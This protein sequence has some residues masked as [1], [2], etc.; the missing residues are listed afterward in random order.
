MGGGSQIKDRI[1]CALPFPE[2]VDII[3]QLR[4]R[5]SSAEITYI[6]VQ[7]D[8]DRKPI[9]HVPIG[10]LKLLLSD[11]S[12][13]GIIWKTGISIE[14]AKLMLLYSIYKKH[15]NLTTV[16]ETFHDKTIIVTFSVLPPSPADCPHLE[17]VH[18]FSAGVNHVYKSP[19]YQHT[20][21]TLTTSSGIHGPQIA[22]WVI[23]TYLIRSH[24]Y[25]LL[26]EK[27]KRKE[28][29]KDSFASVSHKVRDLAGQRLGVLGYGSIGRQ[30]I[31]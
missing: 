6:Y 4:D 18:F 31:S 17:L 21:I 28:W 24:H 12:G 2:P 25:D 14:L 29:A 1:L 11:Q 30:G 22:E 5:F 26:Y 3:N 16:I 19:I 27:Q 8:G 7:Y 23:M 9:T 20:D 15:R 10:N 13:F